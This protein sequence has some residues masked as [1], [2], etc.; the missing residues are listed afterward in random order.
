MEPLMSDKKNLPY[1]YGYEGYRTFKA[2]ADQMIREIAGKAATL[3]LQS[4]RKTA[5]VLNMKP[6][7][8]IGPDDVGAEADV[9]A[10]E[11]EERLHPT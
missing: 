10:I 7:W 1:P 9:L 4:Y 8:E 5:E 6:V 3:S 2:C 11:E